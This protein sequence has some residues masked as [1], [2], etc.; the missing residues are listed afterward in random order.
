MFRQA[1]EMQLDTASK[2]LS[3]IFVAFF[4][5]II[6]EHVFNLKYANRICRWHLIGGYDKNDNN[7]NKPVVKW[8]SVF[9]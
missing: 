3:G 9:M 7:D 4:V 1:N 5:L 6:N 8:P 2:Q